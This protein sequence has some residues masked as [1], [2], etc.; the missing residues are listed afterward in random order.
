MIVIMMITVIAKIVT[1]IT[2]TTPPM[3][4]AVLSAVVDEVHCGS[5]K[6]LMTTGQL[7]SKSRHKCCTAMVESVS[8]TKV[9][10]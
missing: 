3:M 6:E 7:L 4:A 8:A 10:K 9:F 5:P 1:T 2:A